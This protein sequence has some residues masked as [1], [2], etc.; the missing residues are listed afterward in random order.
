MKKDKPVLIEFGV[1]FLGI[2]AKEVV[3]YVLSVLVRD[4]FRKLRRK[5][6]DKPNRADPEVTPDKSM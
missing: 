1:K 6:L 4:G 5:L 2:I 3:P